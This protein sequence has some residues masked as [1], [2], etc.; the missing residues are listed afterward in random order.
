MKRLRTILQY[1]Y[2]FKYITLVIILIVLFISLLFPKSSRYSDDVVSINGRIISKNIDGNKLTLI[3]KGKEKVIVNYYFLKEQEKNEFVVKYDL[4]DIVVVN[5]EMNV[6]SK[7]TIFN[8]FNYKNYLKYKNIYFI[9]DA[10]SINI[11]KKNDNVFYYI[12][13]KIIKRLDNIDG[14]GYLKLFLLGD[15]TLIDNDIL[16]IYQ[17]N[18]ISHLFAVS[19]MHISILI[20]ILFIIL[21]KLTYNNFIKYLYALIFL[22][23]YLF[24]TDYSSS[25]LRASIMF[26]VSGVSKC[27]NIKIS[28]IDIV[29]ITLD[30]ILITDR[31][32][33]FICCF[34]FYC[35]I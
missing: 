19:G 2:T 29:L 7:N 13:S 4:G 22:L 9:M 26:L 24:L 5:G 8:G 20:G 28:K 21:D 1:R 35:G 25:I 3:V 17:S 12:K 30:V 23:F 27:S 6:P 18:G 33:I 15:K 16:N 34:F 10:S 31:V 32:S 14:S 11:E